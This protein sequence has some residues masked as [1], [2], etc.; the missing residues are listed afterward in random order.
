MLAQMTDTSN[1]TMTTV[2]TEYAHTSPAWKS[3]HM[4]AADGYPFAP[5]MY[6]AKRHQR[7]AYTLGFLERQPANVAAQRW[8]QQFEIAIDLE[9]AEAADAMM[10]QESIRHGMF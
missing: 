8:W 1:R 4:D 3:G 10:E 9:C 5:E 2:P 6:F 7:A